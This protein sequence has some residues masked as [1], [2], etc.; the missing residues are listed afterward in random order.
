M[1]IAPT[2]FENPSQ[3][4][5]LAFD[6]KESFEIKSNEKSFILHTSF[7]EQLFFFEI[8]EKGRFPKEEY[9]IYLSLEQLGKITR[10]FLQFE[11]LKE[12]FNSL[13]ILINKKNVTIIKEEKKMKIKIINPANDKEFFINIPLKE[14]DLK[15][16]IDSIIPYVVSLNEKIQILENKVNNLEQ[17]L[18]EIY[19]YKNDLEELKKEKELKKNYEINKSG[20]VNQNEI[21]LFLSWLDKKPIKITLLLDS[22][23]TGIQLILFIINVVENLLQ[24]FLLKIQKVIDLEDIL[25][26][27][28]K[29]KMVFLV[30]IKIILF[31][32]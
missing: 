15:S 24:L 12:V 27:H 17:K 2:T 5:D 11:S 7:N 30:Q 20:I 13:K 16:E 26:Y 25:Q 19:I 14:K 32:L 18:N 8:E 22:K 6:V 4:K 9:N 21:D 31:F 1:M 28:G 29:I 10:Y 23:K 3:K